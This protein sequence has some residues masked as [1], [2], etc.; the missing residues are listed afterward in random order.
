MQTSSTKQVISLELQSPPGGKYETI[1]WEGIPVTRP[2]APGDLRA[3]HNPMVWWFD[4]YNFP[5]IEHLWN[6]KEFSEVITFLPHPDFATSAAMLDRQRLGKQ[7]VEAHMILNV[8]SGLTSGSLLRHPAVRMWVG[9]KYWLIKYYNAM[10][11][12]WG[13]R[14]YNNYILQPFSNTLPNQIEPWAADQ[15]SGGYPPWL[16]DPALHA[17]HRGNLL[18]KNP[19]WYGQWGWKEDPCEGYLWPR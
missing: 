7:R 14:G 11:T 13:V 19:E 16:G 3:D 5:S 15:Y 12:E 10:L 9:H 1:T 8:L 6:E 18:R 4:D 2:K 17:N